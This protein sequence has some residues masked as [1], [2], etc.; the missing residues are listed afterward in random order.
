[1]R[2]IVL[3]AVLAATP[4][5]AEIVDV[6]PNGMEIRHQVRIAAPPEKVWAALIDPARWWGSD[7]TFSGSA[8]NLTLEPRAGGCWCEK[9]PSGGGVMHMQVAHFAPPQTLVLRGALGPLYNLGADGA[10]AFTL[11]ANGAE[12]DL[13]L[14]FRAGGYVKE[15]FQKWSGPVDN[16]LGLQIGNLKKVLEPAR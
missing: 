15:G 1:M 2:W 13:T 6:A 7:H 11:A 14:S 5:A 3:I 16:V 8:S 9:L 10:M 4:A 12:T